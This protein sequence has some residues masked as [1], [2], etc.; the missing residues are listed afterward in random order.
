MKPW[1]A[2]RGGTLV[3]KRTVICTCTVRGREMKPTWSA[4]VA[5]AVPV[6]VPVLGASTTPPTMKRLVRFL[7]ISAS[8]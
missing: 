4:G 6:P 1:P 3:Q 5:V 8:S 2:I 7:P